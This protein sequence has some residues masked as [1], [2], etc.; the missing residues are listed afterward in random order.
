ME[1]E[2]SRL[3]SIAQHINP[4]I[5]WLS[6][7]PLSVERVVRIENL[8]RQVTKEHIE[9]IIK[10]ETS[11]Q[12]NVVLVKDKEGESTG[13]AYVNSTS[14]QVLIYLIKMHNKVTINVTKTVEIG[15]NV[16]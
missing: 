16:P 12:A 6:K 3:I 4:A 13:T 10:N 1:K 9:K 5:E 14:H 7:Q 2:A 11:D 8:P 15:K